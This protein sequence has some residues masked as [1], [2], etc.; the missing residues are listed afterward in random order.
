MGHGRVE[1]GLLLIT[2]RIRGHL[3]KW[4]FQ[5]VHGLGHIVQVSEEKKQQH[6]QVQEM[7]MSWPVTAL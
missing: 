1:A 7:A 6:K 2:S 4:W 3:N 5:V